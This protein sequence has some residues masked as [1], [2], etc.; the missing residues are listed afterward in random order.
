MDV[1][2][3]DLETYK[4][5]R[6]IQGDYQLGEMAVELLAARAGEEAVI[7]YWTL[8]DPQT[9]WE[10]AFE[11]TFGT[12]ISEFYVLFEQHRAAGFPE[13][14]LPSIG[15]SIEDLPQVDR[16]ALVALYN[17]TGGANWSNNT[18]WLS[19]AHIGH[20][21]GVTI[22]PSGRVT[23]LRL[24]RNRLSGELPPE[25]GS[26]TELRAL[27]VWANGLTG[28]ISPGAGRSDETGGTR[29]GR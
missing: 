3:S 7:D 9:P 26:L 10:E 29:C 27:R 12:T 17:A 8:L 28:S 14:D 25:L 4:A 21:Y 16:P 23:E 24:T 11:T 15:P 1:P 19:D 13:V 5:S 6:G 20:W 2:L 22:N 18:Y